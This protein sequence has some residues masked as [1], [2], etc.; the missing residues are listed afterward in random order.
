[1]APS[2]AFDPQRDGQVVRINALLE[3][4]LRHFVSQNPDDWSS[5]LPVAEFS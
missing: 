1:M 5:W 4:F 2:T 3:D